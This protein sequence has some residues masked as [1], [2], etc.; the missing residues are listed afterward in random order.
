MIINRKFLPTRVRCKANVQF[1]C[2]SAVTP[3]AV[4]EFSVKWVYFHGNTSFHKSISIWRLSTDMDQRRGCVE[5]RSGIL[6]RQVFC[7]SANLEYETDQMTSSLTEI[8]KWFPTNLTLFVILL[9]ERVTLA[10]CGICYG[11]Y[12]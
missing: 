6:K 5:K 9:K 7:L 3:L 12:L 1:S 8:S 4:Q 11:K 10:V 2:I